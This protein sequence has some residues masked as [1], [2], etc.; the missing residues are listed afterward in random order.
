MRRE[1]FVVSTEP[2]VRILARALAGRK[3][4]E[5]LTEAPA[6]SSTAA[7]SLRQPVT[8]PISGPQHA[9]REIG[10]PG[11]RNEGCKA[12]KMLGYIAIIRKLDK[13]TLN[14]YSTA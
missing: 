2:P 9:N 11:D 7:P 8:R 14:L 5:P 10:V 1:S 6:K 4:S 3:G 12:L 13:R